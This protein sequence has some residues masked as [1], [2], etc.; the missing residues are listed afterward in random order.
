MGKHCFMEMVFTCGEDKLYQLNLFDDNSFLESE[1]RYATSE[2]L[3]QIVESKEYKTDF[4]LENNYLMWE[5][6]SVEINKALYNQLS[7]IFRFHRTINHHIYKKLANLVQADALYITRQGADL[8]QD[9]DP[10]PVTGIVPLNTLKVSRST[11]RIHISIL[12]DEGWRTHTL[13]GNDGGLTLHS[14]LVLVESEVSPTLD[15]EC[16]G[17]TLERQLSLGGKDYHLYKFSDGISLYPQFSPEFLL[18]SPLINYKV[19]KSELNKAHVDSLTLLIKTLEERIYGEREPQEYPK[20]YAYSRTDNTGVFFDFSMKALSNDRKV[21]LVEYA[22]NKL[23]SEVAKGNMTLRDVVSALKQSSLPYREQTIILNLVY[24]LNNVSG[25]SALD[26]L[27]SCISARKNL[28]K[29][30]LV[31]DLELFSIRAFMFMTNYSLP[32]YASIYI[33]RGGNVDGDTVIRKRGSV[34][35]SL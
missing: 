7:G 30:S 28:R 26:T 1:V 35:T 29:Q 19:F 10:F 6:P 5:G 16:S 25:S 21:W 3:K 31:L 17:I 11:M 20:E 8:L 24:I 13:V 15:L 22:I 27:E 33:A 18:Q 4:R 23:F 9:G 12:G 14:F 32:D 2:Q 34:V